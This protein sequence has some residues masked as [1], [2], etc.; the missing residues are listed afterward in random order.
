MVKTT[1]LVEVRD[2]YDKEWIVIDSFITTTP[3]KYKGLKYKIKK[4]KQK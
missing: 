2:F 1:W 4:I 3:N